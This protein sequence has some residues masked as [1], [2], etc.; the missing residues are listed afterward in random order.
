M[1]NTE[2][3][4]A[5]GRGIVRREFSPGETDDTSRWIGWYLAVVNGKQIHV[6]RLDLW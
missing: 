4:L 5:E 6:S 1:A 3:L 2:S